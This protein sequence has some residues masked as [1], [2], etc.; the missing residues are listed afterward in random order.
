M[1]A[2]DGGSQEPASQHTIALRMLCA[3]PTLTFAVIALGAKMGVSS[4]AH[5]PLAFCSRR[6]TVLVMAVEAV[7]TAR[8]CT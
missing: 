5:V 8:M 7:T 4:D 2:C 3:T 1:E 6:R